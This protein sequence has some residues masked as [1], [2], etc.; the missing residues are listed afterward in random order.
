MKSPR[1]RTRAHLAAMLALAAVGAESLACAGGDPGY[2]V[3]DPLPP[4]PRSCEEVWSSVSGFGFYHEGKA[5]L[6]FS[7]RQYSEIGAVKVTG[8]QVREV[9]RAP[10]RLDLEVEPDAGVTELAMTVSVG[11][12]LPDEQDA[13]TEPREVV[14]DVRFVPAVPEGPERREARILVTRKEP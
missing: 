9:S 5:R 12:T 2:G 3:V 7:A 8:A 14:F 13:P 10:Q 6:Q 1:E 11:C 4:P